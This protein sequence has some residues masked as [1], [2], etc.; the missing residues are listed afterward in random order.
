MICAICVCLPDLP[1]TSWGAAI[2]VWQGT[3]YCTEHLR[4]KASAFDRRQVVLAEQD[5]DT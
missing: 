4:E 5:D 3:A 2:T 1:A